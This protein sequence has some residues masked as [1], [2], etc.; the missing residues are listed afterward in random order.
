MKK[1]DDLEDRMHDAAGK[2]T[3][4]LQ[5]EADAVKPR[6]QWLRTHPKA[7]AIGV[8]VALVLLVVGVWLSK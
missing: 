7:V 3:S 4:Y 2:A 1:L 8:A 5:Q 6:L